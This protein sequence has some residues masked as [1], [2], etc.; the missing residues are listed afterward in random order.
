M[1]TLVYISDSASHWGGLKAAHVATVGVFVHFGKGRL[2]SGTLWKS[3]RKDGA[4]GLRASF[5]V[6][7]SGSFEKDQP[8]V[9]WHCGKCRSKE[10]MDN[11]K[12]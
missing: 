11:S 7:G 8:Q 1:F 3:N 4:E 5:S 9:S 2:G 10:I 6:V 12:Y